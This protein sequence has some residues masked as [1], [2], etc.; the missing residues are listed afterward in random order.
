MT[1]PLRIEFPGG[2]YQVTARDDRREAICLC[3]ADRQS[4]LDL[5]G[6]VCVRHN[7]LCHAHGLMDNYFQIVVGTVD[8]NLSAGMRQL[9]GGYTQ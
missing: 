7:G 8:G 6:K 5:L 1:R 9:G 2:L 4:W 3:D